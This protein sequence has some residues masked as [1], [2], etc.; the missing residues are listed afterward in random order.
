MSFCLRSDQYFR[1]SRPVTSSTE[2]TS[3]IENHHSSWWVIFLISFCSKRAIEEWV[4][5]EKLVSFEFTD[6]RID[7]SAKFRLFCYDLL[8]F[9]IEF[10]Y[11]H[12][13]TSILCDDMISIYN[14]RI[15]QKMLMYEFLV[16]GRRMTSQSLLY[17]SMNDSTLKH[18]LIIRVAL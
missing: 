11:I 5:Y 4:I 1:G 8:D 13:F 10:D 3:I 12:H 15:L 6:D 17:K 16:S 18:I 7:R 14:V 9:S 2:M